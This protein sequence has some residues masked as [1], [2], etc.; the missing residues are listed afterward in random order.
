VRAV[1]RAA[2]VAEKAVDDRRYV[3][4]VD[5]SITVRRVTQRL[6]E[7]HGMRV[8]TAKDGIDALSV[9]QDDVP[10]VMLLDIEMPRMDGYEL[11]GHMR[12]DS[13]FKG[14]PIVMITSR[15]GEKHRNR[16]M[17]LGVDEYLG[18][19]YQEGQLLETIEKVLG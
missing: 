1:V 9:L 5:D 12:S 2:K 15:V 19:P 4:V 14:V 6:L 18:K 13:R 11:A 17:E 10:D 3:L 7:R 16:A 8:R